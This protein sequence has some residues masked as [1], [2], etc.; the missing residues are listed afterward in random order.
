MIRTRAF[1][2]GSLD[3]LKSF[4][5]LMNPF[6]AKV[7]NYLQRGGWLRRGCGGIWGEGAGGIKS[8]AR[9]WGEALAG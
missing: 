1:A 6:R 5:T 8:G 4:R 2:G 3:F 9:G 7:A